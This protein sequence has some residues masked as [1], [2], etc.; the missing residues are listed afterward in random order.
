MSF[1]G[2]DVGPSWSLLSSTAN[3]GDMCI[4]VEDE[5]KWRKDD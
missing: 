2:Q 3:V 5:V 4:I 1:H